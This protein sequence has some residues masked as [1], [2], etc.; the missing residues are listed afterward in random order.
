MAARAKADSP[1]LTSIAYRRLRDMMLSGELKAGAI[2][3]ERRLAK[4][5]DVSRT[6]LRDALFRLEGEGFVIRHDE[7]VLQVKPVTL[8]DYRDALRVR[9]LL[10]T[11][12]ARLAAGRL[13]A[14]TVAH[15]REKVETL[16]EDVRHGGEISRQA[17]EDADNAIHLALAEASGNPLLCELIVSIRQR[18]RLYGLDRRPSR[19]HDTCVEHLAILDAVEAG[20]GE[21]A[22]QAM[23]DHLR[24][25]MGDLQPRLN[26]PRS[27]RAVT[28]RGG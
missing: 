13:S 27:V 14:A 10:E 25:I 12:T 3:Q 5:L 2:L 4:V 1:S 22:A 21:A 9:I 11:E 23:E 24:I 15:I 19:L 28:G 16:L 6:P 7:G 17:I 18:S 8:E 20:D 26:G